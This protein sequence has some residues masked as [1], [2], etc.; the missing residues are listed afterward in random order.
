MKKNKFSIR[1]Q[2]SALREPIRCFE[3]T[4]QP[5]EPFWKFRNA[6]ESESGETE[7]EF[8]GPISE[9]MWWGDEITPKM[10]KDQLYAQ[11]KKGPVTVRLNSPGG[12]LVAASVIRAIM[13]DYPGRV[14]VKVDGLAASAAVMVALGGDRILIQV[15]AYMMIHEAAV[16]IMGYLDIDIL[17]ELID[18]LKT[19]NAGIVEAYA[20]KTKIE[21]EK[22]AKMMADETWMTASEAVAFGFADEVI[23][24]SSKAAGVTNYANLL[25]SRFVNVPSALLH[26]TQAPALVSEQD[27]TSQKERQAQRLAAQAKTYLTKE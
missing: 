14:T 1:Y 11:G 7:I 19:I 13:V 18:E 8:Y 26:T 16:G 24:G 2:Q 27:Q 21:P 12:D 3:G 6:N 25:Q 20:A 5:H 15:S 23:T 10:F 22:L 17:K 9:F 4:A